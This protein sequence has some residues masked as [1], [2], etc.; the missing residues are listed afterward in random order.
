MPNK[1][2]LNYHSQPKAKRERHTFL[3]PI[4]G[5]AT[6]APFRATSDSFKHQ[7]FREQSNLIKDL[8]PRGPRREQSLSVKSHEY[9]KGADRGD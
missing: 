5:A 6:L 1:L 8:Q 4:R 2:T 9:I 7:E 3:Q